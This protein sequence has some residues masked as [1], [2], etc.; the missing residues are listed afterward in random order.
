MKETYEL[1]KEIKVLDE[2]LNKAFRVLL[3]KIDALHQK[4][5]EP[6]KSIGYKTE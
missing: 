2:K 4:K 6:R 3:E 1:R 5:K